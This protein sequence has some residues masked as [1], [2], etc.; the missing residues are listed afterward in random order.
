LQCFSLESTKA[1]LI[2]II[3]EIRSKIESS[4]K[5]RLTFLPL[6]ADQHLLNG[7]SSKYG[8][9][10]SVA[11]IGCSMAHILQPEMVRISNERLKV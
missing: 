7:S 8:G 10:Y 3:T 6:T 2:E 1:S 5:S 4:P 11:F 9:P